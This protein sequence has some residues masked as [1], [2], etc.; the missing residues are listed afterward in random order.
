[1]DA[2]DQHTQ[3][4]HNAMHGEDGGPFVRVLAT[5]LLALDVGHSPVRLRVGGSDRTFLVPR[6]DLPAG[7]TD[8]SRWMVEVSADAATASQVTMRNWE[9][10]PSEDV[11][12]SES[13]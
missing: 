11:S 1:M 6:R 2:K 5:V 8:G 13:V 4:M 7:A 9:K 3:D 12:P 10:A